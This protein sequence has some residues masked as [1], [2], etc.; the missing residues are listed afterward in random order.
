MTLPRRGSGRRPLLFDVLAVTAAVFA[1]PAV[2]QELDILT[3]EPPY[4]RAEPYEANSGGA[5]TFR[6]PVDRDAFSQPM[7]NLSFA[8]RAEFNI[9]NSVFR[10]LWV[11]APSSTRASDGLGPLFNSRACQSCHFR[12]GRGHPPEANFPDDVA[13]SMLMRLSRPPRT[14]AEAALLAEGRVNS[15]PDPVYGGQLQD[16]AVAG[17][18]AEGRIRTEWEESV[19]TLAGGQ[20][21]SLRAP[22]YSVAD[23]GYGPLDPEVMMSVRVAPPMIGLGLLEAIPE[24]R[25]LANAD[26]DDA[27]GDGVSG[28]PNRVWSTADRRLVLGRFGWKANEPTLAQQN[29]H[30]FAG[31]IGLSSPLARGPWGECT[32]AQTACREAIHGDSPAEEPGIEVPDTLMRP[33]LFYTRHLAVP[34]RRGVEDPEVL[35]G[36]KHFYEIGCEACHVSRFVTDRA[37]PTEALSWELIWPYTDLLLHDMGEGLADGRPDGLAGGRE[38][39]TPPLWGIGLTETVVGHT[40]YLHDGRARNLT[41]AILW[42][43]G[44]AQAARDAFAAL[45][46]EDRAALLAF[47]R[48]L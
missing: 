38:W 35:T 39:R 28:R 6:G 37:A 44:E 42:H 9:G 3:P 40:Y 47:L 17:H 15:L 18:T 13:E 36:R 43:G 33:L 25:I 34:A 29:A 12:D 22:T 8:D 1:V 48:S 21:A 5:G 32:E 7:A 11:T 41:E 10:R 2:A 20:T 24:D 14:D 27:D 26:P 30:A 16:L 46:A 19:V 4:D 31:D 23:L 45:P